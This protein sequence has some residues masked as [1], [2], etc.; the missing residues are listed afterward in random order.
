MKAPGEAISSHSEAQLQTGHSVVRRILFLQD[1]AAEQPLHYHAAFLVRD[2]NAAAGLAR[3]LSD[4]LSERPEFWVRRDADGFNLEPV[5]A[6]PVPR[7]MSPVESQERALEAVSEYLDRTE[8][9]SSLL[10]RA[11]IVPIASGGCAAGIAVH[12]AVTERSGLNH[13]VRSTLERAGLIEGSGYE[14]EQPSPGVANAE[15]AS[16]YWLDK[17]AGHTEPLE[18][19]TDLARPVRHSFVCASES[20]ALTELSEDDDVRLTALAAFGVLLNRYSGQDRLVIGL[21]QRW[22]GP[23]RGGSVVVV[24]DLSGDPAFG[25]VLS[26]A[27]RELDL[28][29]RNSTVCFE[30]ILDQLSLTRDGGRSP[31]YQVAFELDDREPVVADGLQ[32]SETILDLDLKLSIRKSKTDGLEAQINY[33]TDLFEASTIKRMLGHYNKLL[34]SIAANPGAPVSELELIPESELRLQLEDWN[35][36]TVDSEPSC[37]HTQFEAQVARA[38]DA[39]ALVFKEERLTYGELNA[40]ANRLAHH[41][42]GLGVGP[43]DLVGVCMDR[44]VEMMVSLLATHK[45]GG[46]YVP[47]DPTYPS[48]R[49]EFM[50]E[51]SSVKVLLTK[52]DIEYPSLSG[53][54]AVVHVDELD[55]GGESAANPESGAV[56]EN[57]AYVIYTSGSTGKPKGVMVEHRNVSNFFVGMDDRVG[58]EGGGRWL[59][60]TSISFDIS[61]LELF[62][63]LTRGFTVVLQSDSDHASLV[64]E[65]YMTGER[66]THLQCTPSTA[67]SLLNIER[68][69]ASLADLKVLLLGGEAL[70]P[71]LAAD[72]VDL[73]GGR[74]VNMYGPTETTIWSSTW[75]VVKGDPVSLGTPISNTSLLVCDSSQRIQPV[76]VPGE[77]CIG[78]DGVVRGYLNRPE[79]T[80]ERFLQNPHGE[81]RIYRTGDRVR[82]RVDGSL[83]FLGRIDFQ[84]KVRGFRIELGEIE[85]AIARDQSV[86]EAVVAAHGEGADMRLVAYFTTRDGGNVD[87]ADLTERLHRELPAYM[88]PAQIVAIEKFPKTPNGKIDRKG[89][90]PPDPVEGDSEAPSSPLEEHIAAIWSDL[91]GR[92]SVSVTVDFFS[93]G[94]NSLQAAQFVNR[95]QEELEEQIFIATVFEHPTVR[96]YA[97]FLVKDYASSVTDRLGIELTSDET[98]TSEQS[99][100]EGDVDQFKSLVVQLVDRSTTFDPVNERAI[101]ILAPPRSGTTLLRVMLAGHPKLFAAAELQLLGFHDMVERR[102]AYQGKFALWLEGAVRALM[103]LKG[104][105]ADQAKAIL[106]E[107]EEE[108]LTTREVY[109]E[110]QDLLG[111]RLLVDK[112]PSYAL[113]PA[114]LRKADREFED[115]VFV[116]L[117][118]HPYAMI[119][120]F[121]KYRLDQV[122]YLRD[123]EFDARRLAELIWL[124]SHRNIIDF[125]DTVPQERQ[126]RI[127]FED[128]VCEPEP[129]MRGFCERVGIGY[130]EALVNPYADIEKKMVDGIYK[131]S[132]PM[133][134][135]KLL[136]RKA[137]DPSAADAWKGVLNDNFISDL[138]W[139]LA[140]A[141]GYEKP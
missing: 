106:E 130:D 46:A 21:P 2:P 81:G 54:P 70:T 49:I 92:D 83:D 102:D 24:L 87:V 32:T 95:L 133:G 98:N 35:A 76:G 80:A 45:A 55:V 57:L 63:T 128:M 120:S 131:E 17:L 8:A 59:A 62:W 7:V 117:V 33:N 93:L 38:P 118:R 34:E 40:R 68:Q 12:A 64:V 140:Q 53:G 11:V 44:S 90:T 137:I 26:Q 84:L 73:V 61:V 42:R 86:N 113:D 14:I 16:Q 112:S 104:C 66:I 115:A 25:D 132:A 36:T 124:V 6:P 18:L 60:V 10:T 58:A 47:L 9:R 23:G 97:R 139:E 31:G 91:L 37:I 108:G 4:V 50:L 48:Q 141:L 116:H 65:P 107:Y 27:A 126:C 129:A 19:P 79:L 109:A 51:D 114:S 123:H 52:S 119:Q 122:M 136:K 75:D 30:D 56:S 121:V 28:A 29:E 88:V 96:E 78:G 3:H 127:V 100:T 110:F 71:S 77:L 125:L 74:V 103:E 105:D 138:T 5:D 22:S 43:D 20:A 72:L 89:L 15:S 111:D 69:A 39:E 134:D 13:L 1:L 41:L 94:G 82:Y 67:A 101:F 99:L 135:T 85:A